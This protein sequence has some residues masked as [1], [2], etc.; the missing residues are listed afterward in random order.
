MKRVGIVVASF[1]IAVSIYYTLIYAL[2]YSSI[3]VLQTI[4]VW[5]GP[6][7]ITGWIFFVALW[8]AFYILTRRVIARRAG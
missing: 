2:R 8:V 1:A 5:I 7:F 6:I 4:V 3:D